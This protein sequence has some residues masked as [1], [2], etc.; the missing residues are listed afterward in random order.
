M[1]DPTLQDYANK[2]RH[3]RLR[4]EG[5]IL[6]VTVHSEGESLQWGIEPH[7]ELGLCFADIAADRENHVVILTGAGDVFCDQMMAGTGGIKFGPAEFDMVYSHAKRL[8]NNL[9]SIEVPIIAAVNGP[10]HIHAELAL[11]SD[12][13]ITADHATFRDSPH[14]PSGLV[15]GDGVHILWP[16][17]LG[18]NRG[19]YFLLT[20]QTLNAAEA[21]NLGVVSEVMPAAALMDRARS[22]ARMILQRP[23]LARRYARDVMTHEYKRL[24]HN[25][26][27]YG[28]ALEGLGAVEHWPENFE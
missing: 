20:G 13:V 27:G 6:E 24:L 14:F 7:A 23:I 8:L 17:L 16:A 2:Y 3:V 25:L 22:L 4:R 21:L 9:L 10:A 12:I 28:L 19:R 1:I 5:G 15:P 11:F 18:P 26:L